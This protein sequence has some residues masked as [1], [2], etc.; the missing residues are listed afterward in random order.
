MNIAALTWFVIGSCVVYAVAVDENVYPWLVLQSKLYKIWLERQWF[1]IRHNPDTPWVRWQ[2]DRNAN[3]LARE[4]LD[5]YK[6]EKENGPS[7]SD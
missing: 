2:I 4:L 3:R 6:Q 7:S 1:L 5:K